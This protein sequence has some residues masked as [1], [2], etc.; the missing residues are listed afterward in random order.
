MNNLIKKYLSNR[1][2]INVFPAILINLL[3]WIFGQ[4]WYY[5]DI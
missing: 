3:F 4:I 2:F 5:T 1:L